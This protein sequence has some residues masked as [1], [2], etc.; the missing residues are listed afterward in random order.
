M[1]KLRVHELARELN[2]T[3]KVLLDRMKKLKISVRSH[4]SALDN[5]EVLTIRNSFNAKQNQK[6]EDINIRSAII[7][8]RKRVNEQEPKIQNSSET[9]HKTIEKERLS[10]DLNSSL[11]L[12]NTEDT[13]AKKKRRKRRRKKNQKGEPAQIIKPAMPNKNHIDTVNPIMQVDG[14][15]N[16]SSMNSCNQVCI[17]T[18]DNFLENSSHETSKATSS[19]QQNDIQ[20]E[21]A[22]L[23]LIKTQFEKD[24]KQLKHEKDMYQNEILNL[25]DQIE[26]LRSEY[27]QLKNKACHV[28]SSIKSNDVPDFLKGI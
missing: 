8:R 26:E 11:N 16:L 22:R 15:I 13:V 6:I 12:I 5:Q 1:A 10:S 17:D 27:E 3:N 20:V 7:R 18:S 2:L 25:I 4:M 19:K 14:H 21:I 9:V 23:R 24:I 28:H